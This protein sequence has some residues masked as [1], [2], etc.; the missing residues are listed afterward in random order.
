MRLSRS[1]RVIAMMTD[2]QAPPG[3][4]ETG[5][6][7]H[8]EAYLEEKAEVVGDSDYVQCRRCG[9][10]LWLVGEHRLKVIKAPKVVNFRYECID[11]GE[12]TAWPSGVYE[13]ECGGDA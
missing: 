3:A 13:S 9:M 7:S 11:C 2:E 12:E 5:D 1:S 4:P 10:T 8:D 6:C